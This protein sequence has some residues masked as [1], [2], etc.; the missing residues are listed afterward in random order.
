MNELRNNVVMLT[1]HSDSLPGHMMSQRDIVRL[2]SINPDFSAL[3]LSLKT[4]DE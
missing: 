2:F 1:S 4:S 3:S